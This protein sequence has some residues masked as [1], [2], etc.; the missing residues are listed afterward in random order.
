MLRKPLKLLSFKKAQ[1]IDVDFIVGYTLFML[2]ILFL[3]IATAN[4][5]KPFGDITGAQVSQRKQLMLDNHLDFKI[6]AIDDFQSICNIS[7]VDV[8]NI[9]ADYKITGFNMPG[10]DS[11]SEGSLSFKRDGDD[12][13]IKNEN[14]NV[15]IILIY[16]H[17][18]DVNYFEKDVFDNKKVYLEPDIG[19]TRV[20]AE[21][22][23]PFF[24]K[25]DSIC[26]D[27]NCNN[28]SSV[29]VGCVFMIDS[30]GEKRSAQKKT[31]SKSYIMMQ[32]DQNQFL[33]L[34]TT[35]VWWSD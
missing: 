17:F 18:V 31:V 35:E 5:A 6:V 10:F 3:L 8:E 7:F 22:D 24:I 2:V 1:I 21:S 12:L 29:T 23:K 14:R 4:L 32:K 11:C 33:S 34:L 15:E 16:P 28:L 30:C 20:E 9:R 19:E 25:I 13:I 26:I 27:N